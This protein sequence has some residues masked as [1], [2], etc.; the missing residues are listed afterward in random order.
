MKRIRLAVL[1]IQLV[2]EA[3]LTVLLLETYPAASVPAVRQMIREVP[4]L[5]IRLVLEAYLT[6]SVLEAWLML[7]EVQLAV[8]SLEIRLVLEAC[9]T[10]SV[11]EA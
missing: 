4:V 5:T 8:R 9:L 11:L 2:L 6:A 10:V 7:P 1:E 3:W